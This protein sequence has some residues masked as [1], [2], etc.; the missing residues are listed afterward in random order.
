MKR[1]LPINQQYYP[2]F[3][4]LFVISDLHLGG[5]PGFQIFNAGSQLEKL[6]NHLRNVSPKKKVAL[7]VNGDLVDFLAERPAMHF[8]PVGAVEKLDRIIADPAF[9]GVWTALQN[10]VSVKN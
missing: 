3:E 1:L 10:F 7:L 2:Q 6:V 5:P 9:T 8:D 4:E